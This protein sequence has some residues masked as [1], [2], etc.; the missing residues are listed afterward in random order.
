MTVRKELMAVRVMDNAASPLQTWVIRL[1]V[2]PPGQAAMIIM[3][4][5]SVG[6][7]AKALTSPKP[8]RGRRIIWLNRPMAAALG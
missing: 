2:T 5:A 1:D 7:R 4:T 8:I 3:P 6:E